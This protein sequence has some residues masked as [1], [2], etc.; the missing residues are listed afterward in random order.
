MLNDRETRA[1]VSIEREL[2]ADR[3]FA[4]QVSRISEPGRQGVA[5]SWRRFHPGGYLG[6]AV[7]YMLMAMGGDASILGSLVLFGLVVWVVVAFCA[8]TEK[9]R[10]TTRHRLRAR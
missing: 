1:W 2:T 4:R 8:K 5:T 6:V 7:A 10:T 9:A 3:G